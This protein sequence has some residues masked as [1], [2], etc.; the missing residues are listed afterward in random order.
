MLC[1]VESRRPG[2]GCKRR[3]LS[4]RAGRWTCRPRPTRTQKPFVLPIA[5]SG[6]FCYVSGT[7]ARQGTRSWP[8]GLPP[9]GR[10]N[11]GFHLLDRARPISVLRATHRG[12][13]IRRGGRRGSTYRMRQPGATAGCVSK[14]RLGD[15]TSR[16]GPFRRSPVSS[17]PRL[18]AS[19]PWAD[20][21]NRVSTSSAC[22]AASPGRSGESASAGRN[23]RVCRPGSARTGQGFPVRTGFWS[24]MAAGRRAV[25]NDRSADQGES[26]A[27]RLHCDATEPW[28]DRPRRGLGRHRGH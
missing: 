11:I 3:R 26:R 10:S 28:C 15:R 27:D 7:L 8:A 21:S 9:R 17:C 19:P 16:G 25:F 23:A 24:N 20:A 6:F 13:P 22:S 12:Q 4:A 14:A 2:H 5:L 1:Q 18:L